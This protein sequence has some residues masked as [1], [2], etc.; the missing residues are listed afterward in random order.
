MTLDGTPDGND[1]WYHDGKYCVIVPDYPDELT[2]PTSS[3]LSSFADVSPS[4]SLQMHPIC[5]NV[6]AITLIMYKTNY[7]CSPNQSGSLNINS[8]SLFELI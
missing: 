4:E 6:H 1:G 5:G 8:H 7:V 2:P 3:L